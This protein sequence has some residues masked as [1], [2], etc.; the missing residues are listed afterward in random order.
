VRDAK[1]TLSLKRDS[2]KVEKREER[3]IEEHRLM[4]KEGKIQ[5]ARFKA[6]NRKNQIEDRRLKK[7]KAPNSKHNKHKIL[8][9][10]D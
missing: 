4:S 6:Q 10:E 5:S 9:T 7:F 1:I 3:E 8:R 2:V